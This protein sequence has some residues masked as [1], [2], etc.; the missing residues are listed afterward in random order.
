M[1]KNTSFGNTQNSGFY[2]TCILSKPKPCACLVPKLP[3]NPPLTPAVLQLRASGLRSLVLSTEPFVLLTSGS[4][5]FLCWSF[6]LSFHLPTMTWLFK[7]FVLFSFLLQ[8]LLWNNLWAS[9]FLS[10]C[11]FLFSVYRQFTDGEYGHKLLKW[12]SEDELLLHPQ[13]LSWRAL[14]YFVC[15]HVC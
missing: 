8:G 9:G 1:W 6:A 3:R 13:H 2:M 5:L 12:S 4:F 11:Y 10:P 7:V 14:I 15:M